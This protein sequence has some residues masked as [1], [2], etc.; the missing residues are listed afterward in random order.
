MQ[1][2]FEQYSFEKNSLTRV[3]GFA[4]NRAWAYICF[5]SIA[6]FHVPRSEGSN[7]ASSLFL[8][9]VAGLA[10]ALFVVG[11]LHNLFEKAFAKREFAFLGPVI[12]S[13][14]SALIPFVDGGGPLFLIAAA[15]LTGIGSALLLASWGISFSKLPPN[16]LIAESCAAYF[17]GVVAYALFSSMH[18]AMQFLFAITLPLISGWMVANADSITAQTYEKPVFSKQVSLLWQVIAGI[19]LIGFAAGLIRDI[20]PVPAALEYPSEYFATY[21]SVTL[22]VVVTFLVLSRNKKTP[23]I[24]LLFRPALIIMILG[25]MLLPILRDASLAP[26]AMMKAGYTC[27]ELIIWI[28]LGNLCHTMC[29]SPVLIFGLGRALVA[30]SSLLGGIVAPLIAPFV[31]DNPSYTVILSFCVAIALMVL[32]NFVLTSD[33]LTK[34]WGNP[35][36][37]Q[38]TFKERCYEMFELYEL[39]ERQKEIACL[40][41]CGHDS[42]YI[43]EKLYIS[44]GT[45]NSHRLR[46]Y[47]K[48]NIHSRQDLLD[49]IATPRRGGGLAETR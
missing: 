24:D 39:T 20:R 14:G 28:V 12:A 48:L 3:V 40:I 5:F 42:N 30:S 1:I 11:V 41:A 8:L 32:C 36:K 23:D 13:V 47:R 34:L 43:S 17:I 27:F 44:K 49:L 29:F 18:V 46:I 2:M 25:V 26:A 45:L 22:L 4:C 9:S 19:I 35:P 15:L 21:L 7:M 38:T 33:A 37:Q 10:A 31:I 16:Q 6:L